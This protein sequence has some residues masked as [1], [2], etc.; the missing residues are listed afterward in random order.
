M[1]DDWRLNDQI[2]YLYQK[3]LV[4]SRFFPHGDVD[5]VH[6]EFCFSKF[7]NEPEDLHDGYCT[8]DQYYW[9]CN[10][11]YHDFKDMFQWKEIER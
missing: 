1:K 4:F 9:I 11:C 5:H 8:L 7:S 3:K 6:C 10:E 2:K